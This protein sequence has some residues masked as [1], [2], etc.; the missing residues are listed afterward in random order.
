MLA[1]RVPRIV[2]WPTT[3]EAAEP[4]LV[5]VLGVNEGVPEEVLEVDAEVEVEEVLVHLSSIVER[6]IVSTL[7]PFISSPNVSLQQ[8]Q[9]LPLRRANAELAS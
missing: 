7:K 2:A 3:T 5:L 9:G 4:V 6:T 8:M 1:A